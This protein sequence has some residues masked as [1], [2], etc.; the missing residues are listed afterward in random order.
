MAHYL[1]FKFEAV[2][3]LSYNDGLVTWSPAFPRLSRLYVIHNSATARRYYI[4]T[5]K[6]LKE[7][8][9]P[10]AAACRELGFAAANSMN[11][12]TAIRVQM[13]L[14]ADGKQDYQNKTPGDNGMVGPF[15]AEH[16]LIRTFVSR[17]NRNLR[18]I[19][20]ANTPFINASR[21]TLRAVFVNNIGAGNAGH[22]PNNFQIASRNTL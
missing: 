11:G 20:L 2:H 8:F 15:D 17:E 1:R 10:R 21:K 19:T 14:K 9:D 12:V 4:G 3:T 22:V 6:D 13:S 7:R 5:T 16:L 18:N